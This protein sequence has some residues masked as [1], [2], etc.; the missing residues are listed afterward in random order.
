MWGT[1]PITKWISFLCQISDDDIK[2]YIVETFLFK[3]LQITWK[4]YTV[5]MCAAQKWTTKNDVIICLKL[6]LTKL[7]HPLNTQVALKFII[8]KHSQ[9]RKAKHDLI[10]KFCKNTQNICVFQFFN[11]YDF[12]VTGKI[13]TRISSPFQMLHY[14]SRSSIRLTLFRSIRIRPH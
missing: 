2:F 12:F 14:V 1:C 6:F 11:Q 7:Q 13:S 10:L 5:C 8:Q 4:M 9:Q 3:S